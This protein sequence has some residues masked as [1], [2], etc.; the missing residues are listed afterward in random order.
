LLNT[1]LDPNKMTD[2]EKDIWII[3]TQNLVKNPTMVIECDNKN[4]YYSDTLPNGRVLEVI[5]AI[6]GTEQN[7][8]ESISI[9]PSSNIQKE[10]VVI[11]P[12]LI[13]S[14]PLH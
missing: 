12:K 2:D 11:F 14:N 9:I 3:A 10:G 4:Y 1:I 5:V 13:T 6:T 8:V 7:I